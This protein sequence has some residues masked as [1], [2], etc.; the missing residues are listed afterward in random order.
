M[1]RLFLY[2]YELGKAADT[3]TRE[4][5]Q[6]KPGETFVITADTES[7]LRVVNATAAAA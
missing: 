3:L 5:F 2:E 6:L 7:S 4:L 1:I